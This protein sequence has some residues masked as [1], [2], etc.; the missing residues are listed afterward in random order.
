MPLQQ[1]YPHLHPK[2][3]HTFIHP[4]AQIGPS[5][6]DEG[7]PR[8]SKSSS[9]CPIC[10]SSEPHFL[11]YDGLSCYSCR[12]FFRRAHQKT[13]NP[14]FT[15]VFNGRC[16]ITVRNRRS[17]RKCR[18]DLCLQAGMRPELVLD[19]AQKRQRFYSSTLIRSLSFSGTS[20]QMERGGTEGPSTSSGGS[21]VSPNIS[22]TL[23]C[24]YH[25]LI[26]RSLNQ[27]YRPGD[28]SPD[29][30]PHG[31]TTNLEEFAQSLIVD[32]NNLWCN[33]NLSVE[34]V[35]GITNLHHGQPA[36]EALRQFFKSFLSSCK[37]TF[38][39][40][41]K[42]R[43]VF[44]LFP[45]D[46]QGYVLAQNSR[47]YL[48][49]ILATYLGTESGN[50]QVEQLLGNH[51]PLNYSNAGYRSLRIEEFFS[52]MNRPL[53][54][55]VLSAITAKCRSIVAL[56]IARSFHGL[57][58]YLLLFQLDLTLDT[59]PGQSTLRKAFAQATKVICLSQEKVDNPI[60]EQHLF[61]SIKDLLWLCQQ[62]PFLGL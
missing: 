48:T 12:A 31:T 42:G 25:Q 29:I 15:C 61:D 39:D 43:D 34:F 3:N 4:S 27:S 6:M 7:E 22:E 1:L 28:R 53:D 47:L 17:C 57:V 37:Q 33:M 54:P 60:T 5:I 23:G 40:F 51:C 14:K 9:V 46:I 52:L 19:E 11:H 16:E 49:Y 41:A 44:K 2:V 56:K 18:Y 36:G 21:N 35:Q 59:F 55:N 24:S 30:D 26:Q 32:F 62:F 50:E 45:N 10:Q 13:R 20:S 58:A 38:R 8:S